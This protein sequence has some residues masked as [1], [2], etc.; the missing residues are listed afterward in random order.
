[1]ATEFSNIRIEYTGTVG[2]VYVEGVEVKGVKSLYY[3]AVAGCVPTLQ[4]NI[5]APNMI[6]ENR[7]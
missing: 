6:I 7:K 4:I 3:E 5:N 2:H 1:M